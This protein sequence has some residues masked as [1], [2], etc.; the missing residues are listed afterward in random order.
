VVMSPARPAVSVHPVASLG[1]RGQAAMAQETRFA[2][3]AAAR[4]SDR[5]C[6]TVCRII[7][8]PAVRIVT[9]LVIEPRHRRQP[10]RLVPVDLIDTAAGQIRLRCTAAEFELLDPAEDWELV[11]GPGLS[12]GAF[13]MMSYTW[14]PAPMRIVVREIVPAGEAQVSPG[15]RVRA[16]DGDIGPVQGL[17]VDPADRRVT[18]VLVRGGQLWGRRRAAIPVSA[19]TAVQD[20]IRLNITRRQARTCH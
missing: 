2:I 3:G 6:G 11:G 5:R 13:G 10:G 15:D 20:G 19:V 8:D 12:K 16:L 14:I 18:Y 17:V 1:R 9:H 7:I 4:C